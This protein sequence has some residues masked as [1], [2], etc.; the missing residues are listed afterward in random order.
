MNTSEITIHL[1]T[2]ELNFAQ[3]YASEHGLTIEELIDRYI[4]RLRAHTD[5]KN[6]SELERYSGIVPADIDAEMVYKEHLLR[7]HK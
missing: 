7:K 6:N 5:S 3:K 1:S 2:E 4:K